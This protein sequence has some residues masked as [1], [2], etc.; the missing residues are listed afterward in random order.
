MVL[1]QS[2][3]MQ[4]FRINS[5]NTTMPSLL[6]SMLVVVRRLEP[7]LTGL[8]AQA[9]GSRSRPC[10]FGFGDSLHRVYRASTAFKICRVYRVYKVHRAHRVYVCGA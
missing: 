5:R 3:V 1:Q 10:G 4:D 8:R 7:N 2:E 6:A 9:G